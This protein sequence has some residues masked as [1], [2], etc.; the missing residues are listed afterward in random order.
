MRGTVL[1]AAGMHYLRQLA[2]AVNDLYRLILGYHPDDPD[3]KGEFR[4]VE[5]KTGKAPYREI[6][7][8]PRGGNSRVD[9]RKA[10]LSGFIRAGSAEASESDKRRHHCPSQNG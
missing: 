2:A 9:I 8:H 5:V 4:F 3:W 1:L 6:V 10:P 7:V